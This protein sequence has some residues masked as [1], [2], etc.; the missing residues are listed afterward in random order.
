MYCSAD[1]LLNAVGRDLEGKGACIVCGRSTWISVVGGR[2]SKIEPPGAVLHVVEI[3]SPGRTQIVCEASPMFDR[4]D[5]LQYWLK[6]YNGPPGRVYGVE[7][8]MPRASELEAERVGPARLE[9][10]S[11][12]G[13]GR[14]HVVL[15]ADCGCSPRSA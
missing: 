1:I 4:E 14:V 7:E 12:S 3:Q 11:P 10:E 9:A 8:F 2:V 6:S 15:C 13:S 5:C